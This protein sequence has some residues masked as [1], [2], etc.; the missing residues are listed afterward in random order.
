[1]KIFTDGSSRGNPGPGGWASILISSDT[2]RELG[3]R[4]AHTTN[5]RME[6]TAALRG[7]ESAASNIKS[8]EIT[9]ITDSAYLLNGITKWIHGWKQK[10]WIGSQ[11]QE[12][13]NRDLW[14]RLSDVIDAIIDKGVDVQWKI[15]KGHSGHSLNERCDKIATSFADGD[16]VQLYN[17][18]LVRYEYDI[19]PNGRDASHEISSLKR[20]G[21]KSSNPKAYSYVSVVDGVVK[22]DKTWKECEARVK[23]TSGARF[24]K[25]LNMVDEKKIVEEFGRK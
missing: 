3:G 23:G 16:G 24:K 25:S 22:V 19:R 1:M 11:K 8:K 12:I 9:V 14:E 5:N 10:N 20:P 4:E 18:P 2:V 15:I 7:L 6:M 13:V 17:G 21:K